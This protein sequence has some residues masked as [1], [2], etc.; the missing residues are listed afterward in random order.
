MN[1]NEA[2]APVAGSTEYGCGL[3]TTDTI[4]SGLNFL[5]SEDPEEWPLCCG[6]L[7]YSTDSTNLLILTQDDAELM[8]ENRPDEVLS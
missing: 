2:L 6:I 1:V 3:S 7:A 8:A 5:L 4:P